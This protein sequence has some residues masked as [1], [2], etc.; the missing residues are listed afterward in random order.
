[1]ND[2]S[3]GLAGK[4]GGGDCEGDGSQEKTLVEEE[5]CAL[6]PLHGDEGRRHEGLVHS[7]WRDCNKG[8]RGNAKEK[9]LQLQDAISLKN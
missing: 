2:P 6:G 4:N 3:Q 9:V 5:K 1:M 8:K 7:L